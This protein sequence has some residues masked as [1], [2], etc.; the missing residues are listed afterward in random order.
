M[1]VQ[2]ALVKAPLKAEKSY[3]F[4]SFKTTRLLINKPS[5]DVQLD[6]QSVIRQELQFTGHYGKFTG[7]GFANTTV[8]VKP[9]ESGAV[10]DF[11]GTTVK[12]VIVDGKNVK[13]IRGAENIQEIEYVNGASA[14]QVKILDVEG[15]PIMALLFSCERVMLEIC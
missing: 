9:V 10:V 3:N 12:K 15:E 4:N 6:G 8:R 2:L 5:V 11:A 14:D 13:E 7:E 1:L